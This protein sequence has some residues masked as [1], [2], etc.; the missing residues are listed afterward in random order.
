MTSSLVSL[1]FF[2]TRSLS[3]FGCF[4]LDFT[5]AVPGLF[6]G[7]GPYPDDSPGFLGG[8]IFLVG[9]AVAGLPL[10]YLTVLPPIL[11][12]LPGESK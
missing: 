2:L 11:V 7:D 1:S 12:D 10:A 3:S 4:F 8:D 5:A 9:L 6:F